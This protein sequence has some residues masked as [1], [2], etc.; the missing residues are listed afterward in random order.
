MMN[1]NGMAARLAAAG[2]AAAAA[3]ETRVAAQ[4]ATAVSDAVAGSDVLVA[5][6][7]DGR[8]RLQARGLVAR[9]FG[10]RRRAADPRFAG[11]LATLA[12]GGQA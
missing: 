4:L 2:E 1:G 5:A 11:L 10:S 3:A 12:R 9:A 6:A 7:E 8:V